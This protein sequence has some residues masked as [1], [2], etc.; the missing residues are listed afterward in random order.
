MVGRIIF[1]AYY[2]CYKLRK[3][4]TLGTS[5]LGV[6]TGKFKICVRPV[7]QP[8]AA[9]VKNRFLPWSVSEQE[10]AKYSE[11]QHTALAIP[12]SL[13]FSAGIQIWGSRL[14][15]LSQR[16]VSRCLIKVLLGQ[17]ECFRE[18]AW[19]HAPTGSQYPLSLHWRI[20]TAS[21]LLHNTTSSSLHLWEEWWVTVGVG[22]C[23][24]T[25]GRKFTSQ[26]PK[27]CKKSS[28][29]SNTAVFSQHIDY[30]FGNISIFGYW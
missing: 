9:L 7:S 16:W 25:S 6:V 30:C 1:L 2:V 24:N 23:E 28:S 11:S 15:L 26:L 22:S 17:A 3:K 12:Y 13:L 29:L 10:H 20:I 18:A 27:Q 21:P 14:Q 4:K 19:L 8:A 5:G